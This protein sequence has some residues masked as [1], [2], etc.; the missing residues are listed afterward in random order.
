M[1][2]GKKARIAKIP[3]LPK[4]YFLFLLAGLLD[5]D[6]GKKGSGFGL[7]T[8]SEYL[9]EFCENIFKEL[10]LSYA[11][12]PWFYKNHTY[13]QIY[14]HKKDFDNLLKYIPLKNEDKLKF[15]NLVIASVA[16]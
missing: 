8:A 9:A 5:T 12:C 13:H 16:Q 3:N 6:G 2:V 14:V 15:I 7:S 10:E 4:E 1:I 11:S